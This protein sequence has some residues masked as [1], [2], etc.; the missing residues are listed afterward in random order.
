MNNLQS[1]V[2]I[3]RPSISMPGNT[4]T[5]DSLTSEV[6][7]QHSLRADA[8][9][10]VKQL[11]PK[12]A[13]API[14]KIAGAARKWHKEYTLPTKFGDLCPTAL[15]EHWQARMQRFRN[16]F[17][18]AVETFVAGYDLILD[19][20]RRMHNGTFNPDDYP[21]A[22]KV[23]GEF[24]FDLFQ[25][26]MPRGEDLTVTHL[27]EHRIAMIRSEIEASA[28][29]A[30]QQATQELTRRILEKVNAITARMQEDDPVFRDSLIGN[31]KEILDIA[32]AMNLA[33][34]PQVRQL[35]TECRA[36]L[37]LAPSLLRNSKATRGA[38][39][40]QGKTITS[41]FSGLMGG[42][43]LDLPGKKAA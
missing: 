16:E 41:R 32:P 14:Q 35:I 28:N 23:G 8:G 5:D 43:K 9:R 21:P 26:P 38:V 17:V 11:Y 3:V 13:L 4:R 20:A 15:Y 29:Q 24:N 10:Y 37:L 25:A 36:K 27:T 7:D 31:L 34:D 2:L 19:E 22:W 6:H 33:D 12:A 30:A 42:R 40:L 18:T 1:K 39:L